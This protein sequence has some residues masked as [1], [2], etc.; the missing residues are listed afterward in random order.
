MHLLIIY[1]KE[2]KAVHIPVE[3]VS[4]EETI[5]KTLLVKYIPCRTLVLIIY[6]L[7]SF[8]QTIIIHNKYMF[9]SGT[10]TNIV[11]NGLYIISEIEFLLHKTA[12][13]NEVQCS[14]HTCHL[15]GILNNS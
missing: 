10:F 8:S 11:K 12:L 4:N 3:V 6:T 1:A 2:S 9:F 13:L 7:T 14:K 15:Q 5:M